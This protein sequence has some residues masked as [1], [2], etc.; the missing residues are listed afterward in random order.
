MFEAHFGFEAYEWNV[1]LNTE[2]EVVLQNRRNH[3][4]MC[5]DFKIYSHFTYIF[6]TGE[7]REKEKKILLIETISERT[8]LFSYAEV[9]EEK[10]EESHS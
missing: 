9:Q 5:G 3:I 4:F 1:L 10:E 2:S 7:S 6:I 8:L